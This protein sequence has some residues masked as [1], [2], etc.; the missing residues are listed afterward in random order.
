[1]FKKIGAGL[2]SPTPNIIEPKNE[3]KGLPVSYKGKPFLFCIVDG[4]FANNRKERVWVY[5]FFILHS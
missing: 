4:H 5:G 2:Y 3:E 1:L